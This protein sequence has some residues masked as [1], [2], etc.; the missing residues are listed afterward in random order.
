MEIWKTILGESYMDT[1]IL[2]PFGI[3]GNIYVHQ[4]RFFFCGVS[5]IGNENPKQT[6]G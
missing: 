1:L 6:F 5:K 4:Q 2:Q 3:N